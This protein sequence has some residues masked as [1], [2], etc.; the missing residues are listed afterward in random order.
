M[1]NGRSERRIARTVSV[2][3]SLLDRPALKEQT[4]SGKHARMFCAFAYTRIQAVI[5]AR[6]YEA[7]IEVLDTNPA[8]SS[9][10]GKYK[11]ASR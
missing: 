3:V 8:Y 10:I 5:R 6:S 4:L 2:E 7:G 1:P 11:F 9:I